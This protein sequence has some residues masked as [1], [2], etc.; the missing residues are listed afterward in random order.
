M[1]AQR[2]SSPPQFLHPVALGF[3]LLLLFALLSPIK[4]KS[5]K[6]AQEKA[7]QEESD[8]APP[9]QVKKLGIGVPSHVPL[10]V[11]VKN[12]N[13]KKWAHDLQVEVTNTSDKPI[14]FL[15][16]Y[17]T[18]PGIKGLLG[19]DVGFWL[20]YGRV[21]LMEFSTPIQIDDVPIEPSEKYTFKIPES[22]AKGW[23]YLRDKESRPEPKKLGLVFQALNFGDGTGFVDS[24]GTPVNIHKKI[25][26]NKTCVPPPSS[27]P[28]EQAFSFLPAS[29]LPVKLFLEGTFDLLP[30]KIPSA[31]IFAAAKA[32]VTM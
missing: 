11:K 20:K 4:V 18:L 5:S 16:L 24:G 29:F 7:A 8:T 22:S 17:V 13:S 1:Y 21:E 6:A 9:E 26:L 27:F 14:Y 23:D 2:F 31:R 30:R 12:L 28:T 3:V 19:S 15:S 32:L 10:R 25:N